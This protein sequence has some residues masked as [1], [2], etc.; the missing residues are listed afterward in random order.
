MNA[1]EAVMKKVLIASMREGAGKTSVIAGMSTAAGKKC[2]YIKPLGD[3]LV[4]RRKKNVDHDAA[5]LMELLGMGD[6]P[7]SI[8]IGF[9]HS[10][11][12]YRYDE[13]GTKKALAAMA[14]RAGAGRDVLFIEGGRDMAFGASI[15]LDSLSQARYLDARMAIV[16]GGDPDLVM[17]DIHLIHQFL[18]LTRVNFTGV[19]IN[20]IPDIDD[21]RNSY[22]KSI[23][24]L[25]IAVLGVLPYKE[26][27]TWFSMAFLAERFHA[28]VIAG[29]SGMKNIVRHTLV[30]AMSPEESFRNP[31]FNKEKK[32]IITSGDR[33]DMVVGALEGDTAGI[34]LTNNIVP[35]HNIINAAGE[36]GVPLL[37]VPY[38]TYEVARQMDNFDALLLSGED[39]KIQLLGR[40]A[41]E[42]IRIGELIG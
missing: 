15:N 5:V 29:E 42:Y 24:D 13:E 8:S 18:N 17:D 27:L 16:V 4:Y 39:E 3:R 6:D 19:I 30:G 34:I 10:K 38:D 9:T 28:R 26:Q 25:G 40:L 1:E 7:E 36:K 11:L 23:T 41:G 32:L 12:R 21:F 31:I 14:E 35:P 22:Q 2:G 20:R 37:L 33:S